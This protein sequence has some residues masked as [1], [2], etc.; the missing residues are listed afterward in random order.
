MGAVLWSDLLQLDGPKE[1]AFTE[2]SGTVV[3]SMCGTRTTGVEQSGFVVKL[4]SFL[5]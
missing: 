5:Q 1:A 4:L 2:T 3:P